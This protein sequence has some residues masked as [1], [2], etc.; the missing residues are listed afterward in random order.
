MQPKVAWWALG[1]AGLSLL[2]FCGG[3]SDARA[4][5]PDAGDARRTAPPSQT[6]TPSVSRP[7]PSEAEVSELWHSVATL[8]A[9]V[10]QLRQEVASL[11]AQSSGT[12]GSGA[13]ASQPRGAPPAN[14]SA[15]PA[16]RNPPSV[17]DVPPAEAT[18]PVPAGTAVVT[19]TYSGVVRSVS[20][21]RVVLT[22]DSGAPLSLS[23]ESRTKVTRDGK[24]IGLRELKRGDRVS[25]VVDMLGQHQTEE[26]SVLPKPNAKE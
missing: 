13:A 15:T 24:D 23:V 26:I 18:V 4:Q 9:E 12:G 22:D 5:T 7:A 1:I 2:L 3:G 17:S 14:G 16:L 6:S 25:A 21:S 8:R 10:A 20:P 11:R 19:A